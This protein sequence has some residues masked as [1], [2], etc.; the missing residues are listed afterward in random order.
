MEKGDLVTVI[1]G[2]KDCGDV[3]ALVHD[4]FHDKAYIEIIG[5][6]PYSSKKSDRWMWIDTR[7]L[8]LMV[9]D[10]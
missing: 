2:Y 10:E 1:T 8:K 7:K 6:L 5:K 4:T 3:P 9:R